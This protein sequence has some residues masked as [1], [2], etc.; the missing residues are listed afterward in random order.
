MSPRTL[1]S[2]FIA[3]ALLF[4]LW[5]VVGLDW[6]GVWSEIRQVDVRL[7][8]VALLV[9]YTTLVPRAL[10]WRRMLHNL[11]HRFPLRLLGEVIFLS[12]FINHLIPAK[13]GDLYRGLVL[14]RREKISFSLATGSVI[15]ERV[16][17]ILAL[18][19]I[20]IGT[21]LVFVRGELLTEMRGVLLAASILIVIMAGGLFV[22]WRLDSTMLERFP[23]S[24]GQRFE[25]LQRGVFKSVQPLWLVALL[26][27]LAWAAEAGRFLLVAN[28]LGVS[29]TLP[30]L[31]FVFAAGALLLAAPTPGG[32]GAVEGGMV[33]VMLLLDVP[34]D[35][36]AAV[37]FLDRLISYWLVLIPG[38]GYYFTHA[39]LRL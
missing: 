38:A 30:Q 8:V 25:R 31:L 39:R 14:R 28:A 22:F 34:V 18:L 4:A 33:G 12:W 5:R 20:A 21:A 23:L 6:R 19:V 15:A 32:L 1:F 35:L 37:A 2:F 36:A 29:L 7:Y 17:D 11:G 9:Y 10:R 27:G 26:T 13:M 24:L 16:V 3:V